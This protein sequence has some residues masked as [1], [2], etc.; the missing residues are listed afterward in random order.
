MHGLHKYEG[1][2]SDGGCRTATTARYVCDL[3]GR[4]TCIRLSSSETS[5]NNCFRG[6]QTV[7]S[8]ATPRRKQPIDTTPCPISSSGWYGST[9]IDAICSQHH[10]APVVDGEEV[11]GSRKD[12]SLQD[13]SV[14][15]A[16][17]SCHAGRCPPRL[18]GHHRAVNCGSIVAAF[19]IFIVP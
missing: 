14:G 13:L 6:V 18:Q 4:R 10:S 7:V 12:D 9:T 16:A 2:L 5:A 3:L 17:N 1:V 11:I 15:L 19:K 8:R